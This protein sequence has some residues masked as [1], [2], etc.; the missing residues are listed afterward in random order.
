[1]EDCQPTPPPPDRRER[2]PKA[3]LDYL[4]A[5]SSVKTNPYLAAF[6][7]SAFVK[8]LQEDSSYE[9]LRKFAHI[10]KEVTEVGGL[11]HT[12]ASHTRASSTGTAHTDEPEKETPH[13]ERCE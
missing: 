1:M 4:L 11:H 5:G 8:A 3:A 6:A 13:L 9:S 2:R 10:K 12:H 7:K